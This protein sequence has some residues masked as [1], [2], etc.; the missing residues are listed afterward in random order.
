MN[1]IN[2][3]YNKVRGWLYTIIMKLSIVVLHHHGPQNVQALLASIQSADMP[4]ETEIFVMDNGGRGGND[5]IEASSYEGLPVRFE[6]IPNDGFPAGQ[7]YGMNNTTGQYIAVVNPD[8]VLEKDSLMNLLQYLEANPKV[9]MASAQLYYEDGRLQDNTRKFPKILE[10]MW[11]RIAQKKQP[12]MHY[13]SPTGEATPVD[14]VTGAFYIIRRDVLEQVGGHDER[15]F[16]FMSDVGTCRDVWD[17]G[18][19]V[20]QVHNAKAQHGSE[21]LSSGGPWK[22]VRSKIGRIHI[23]DACTYFLH[24]AGK[25]FPRLSPSASSSANKS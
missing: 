5:M 1:K 10:M 23:K 21:R 2:F 16:L 9:G 8:I 24:Y 6:S 12:A 20:H 18:F 15:Y 14:W 7:N 25:P 3:L 4:E 19:G 11:R 17:A 22:M 13:G